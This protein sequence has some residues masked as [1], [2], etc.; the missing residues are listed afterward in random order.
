MVFGQRPEK[1]FNFCYL[2]IVTVEET[3]L[4]VSLYDREVWQ[5]LQ[6]YLSR[7]GG[8]LVTVLNR[9]KSSKLYLID[10]EAA[11]TNLVT[12]QFC[13]VYII[14]IYFMNISTQFL[15]FV[16]RNMKSPILFSLEINKSIKLKKINILIY[17]I[18]T[19][20]LNRVG[21]GTKP[22]VILFINMEST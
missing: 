19:L 16:F 6:L 12:S 4:D 1:S 18:E 20:T 21:K 15:K 2:D 5:I 7:S 13:E 10:N 9:L 14:L 8:V 17:I 11:R 22:S 3:Y